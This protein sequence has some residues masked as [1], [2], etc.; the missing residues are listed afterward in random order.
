MAEAQVFG[1]LF[2][3]IG[4]PDKHGIIGGECRLCREYVVLFPE[5]VASW[6]NRHV[7]TEEE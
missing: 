6:E 3:Q 7:C 4:E 1:P 2:S 5:D